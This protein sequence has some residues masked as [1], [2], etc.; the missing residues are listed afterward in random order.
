MC[1]VVKTQL[2]RGPAAVSFGELLICEKSLYQSL[3]VSFRHTRYLTMCGYQGCER[4][5][6]PRHRKPD[7]LRQLRCRRHKGDNSKQVLYD[8]QFQAHLPSFL[9]SVTRAS[10]FD[11]LSPSTISTAAI[12]LAV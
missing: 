9:A 8:V 1:V 3:P 12:A 10:F 2:G 5:W 4:H 6:S 11:R 7:A